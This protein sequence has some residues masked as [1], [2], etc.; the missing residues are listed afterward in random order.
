MNRLGVDR[1]AE[2]L[3]RARDVRVLVVG[4][5]ML[6]RYISG[7]VGRI[8][9]EAPVPVVHVEED[10]SAV[11]GAANVAANVVALGARCALVGCVGE[12]EA[13][14]EMR[15][16]LSELGV[17]LDGLIATPARPTTVKTRVMARHQQIV[18]VDREQVGDVDHE[19]AG[20]LAA[21]VG[22]LAG[23]CSA[24][25]LEDYNK[26]VL[27]PSVVRAVLQISM[28]SDV[29]SIVDPKRQRFFDYA[30]VTVFKP[31]AKELE[32][33]LG[34]PLRPEDSLWMESVRERLACEHLLLTLGEQGMALHSKGGDTVLL[35]T[36]ARAVY[37]VSGAGDTVTAVLAV[38]LAAGGTVEE[39]AVLANHAAALEVAKAGV[40]TVTPSEI[41]AHAEEMLSA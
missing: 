23:A 9:P 12:D 38:S 34:E 31:N 30:G 13:G 6:D 25:A 41:L 2:L 7:T 1:I 21:A 4:D 28:A 26:G 17:D 3:E 14:Q 10:S 22:D 11:G 40:A 37:D 20:R 16:E 8:S 18:R 5:L 27:V 35:P 39:S 29:P 36:A 19:A 15:A 33:A 24:L 32:D